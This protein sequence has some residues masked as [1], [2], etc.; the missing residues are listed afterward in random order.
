MTRLR[1][2]VMKN[3]V[4]FISTPDALYTD[5]LQKLEQFKPRV[6]ISY[7]SKDQKIADEVFLSLISPAISFGSTRRVSL[8]ESSGTMKW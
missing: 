4:E 1:K 7:S 6:F 8:R 2:E 3:A 5:L